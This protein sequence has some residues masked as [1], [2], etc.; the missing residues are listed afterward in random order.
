MARSCSAPEG[1]GASASPLGASCCEAASVVATAAACLAFME[2]AESV[3]R[4]RAR[5]VST[6][7][8]EQRSCVEE[9]KMVDILRGVL[10]LKQGAVELRV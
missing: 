4:G 9:V 7:A 1:A 10:G 6:C 3:L 8:S 5:K 2:R